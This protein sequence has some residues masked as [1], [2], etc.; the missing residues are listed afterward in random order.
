MRHLFLGLLLLAAGPTAAAAP[1]PGSPPWVW[2][3]S[4]VGEW[5]GSYSD[6]TSARVSYRLVS[7]G[8]ALLETLET[9]HDDQMVTIYHRDGAELLMTHYCSIG[10]QTRMRARGLAGNRLAFAF[11]D[12]TNVREPEE[13]VMTGL[14]LTFAGPGRLVHEWTSRASGQEQTGRFEFVREGEA[15]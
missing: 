4:L 9:G 2:L 1:D 13:N 15:K 14:V 8:T 12:S 6:G 3:S 5:R 11:V 7:N 10:N